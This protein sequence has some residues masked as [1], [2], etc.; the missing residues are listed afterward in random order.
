MTKREKLI[1]GQTDKGGRKL[2]LSRR[3]YDLDLPHRAV[4]V[5]A[6][7]CDMANKK[8]ECWPS[9]VTI[10]KDLGLSR[11][12]IFRALNDLEKAGLIKRIPR[13]R[14]TGGRTSSLI[15]LEVDKNV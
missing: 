10:S 5:Y 12:T 1:Y 14:K 15:R 7:L 6:Y 4:S 3:I 11:R 13:R 2:I 9:T 8:R